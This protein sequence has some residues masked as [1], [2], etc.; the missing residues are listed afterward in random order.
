MIIH[1][2]TV[3]HVWTYLDGSTLVGEGRVEESGDDI[4]HSDR[5]IVLKDEVRVLTIMCRIAH[6][7]NKNKHLCIY[8]DVVH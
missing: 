4:H 7:V 8:V 2:E 6:L 5:H 3:I 1:L